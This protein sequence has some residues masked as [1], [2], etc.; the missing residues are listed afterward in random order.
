M[1]LSFISLQTSR[2]M[3]AKTKAVRS[4]QRSRYYSGFKELISSSNRAKSDFFRLIRDEVHKSFQFVLNDGG[5]ALCDS[6]LNLPDLKAYNFEEIEQNLATECPALLAALQGCVMKSKKKTDKQR[7]AMVGTIASMLGHFRRPRKCCQLQTLNGIQ[8]WM[9]GCKRKVFT[10]FNHLSWCVGVTGARKAV[11]RI[12]NNHD[13][14]LQGWKNALTRFDRGEFWTEKEPLGYSLCFDN[15]NHFITARHQSKQRQNRQLNLT[16]MYASRD[17]IPTTDL[18]NDK[19]DSDTI[20]GIPVSHLL[21]SSQEECMLRDEMV[22]ITSRIL[23]QEITPL[24]HLKNEWDI[25]H[26]YSEESSKQSDMVPLGVIEKDESK[27]DEMI[28][29]LD[30]LHKYVPRNERDG[31]GTLILH[32]DGLS[33]ERVK[34]AQ[35]ARING[36]T[37]WAQLTGLQPC[38]QEWH[39]QVIILQDIY[40]HLYNSTSGKDKMTLFHLRNVFGHHNVT[41]TVKKSYNFNAEFLEF[42]THGFIAAYALHLVGSQHSHQPLDIPSSKEDQVQ[43]V[44]SI[45]RQIVDDVFLPSQAANILHSPYCVCKDYVD[46]TTMICCDNTHCQEGSWFHLQC[47]GIPED[48][49]PKGKWYCSTECRRASSHKKKKS[50]KR[51]TKTNEQAKIDRV[52]EYNKSVIFHGLNFLIRRDAI[53]QNDGNRMIAHWKS[54]LVTFLTG[55]HNKYMVLAHRLLMGVNG[56][57]SDRIAKT[58]VWNRTV[59]P[60]GCPGRNI[61]MDLQMEMLNKTYKENVRVSRGKLTSA[62]INRHSKIIGI[63]QSLSNL[64]D[65]LTSTR[66][67]QSATSSPDRTTDTQAL[68]KMVLDYNSFDNIP[69]RAHDSFPQFQHQRPPLE[70]PAKL[71]AKLNKLTES[72][73][74]RSHLVESLNQ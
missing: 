37:Q 12:T 28:E 13:E 32:G 8:M 4:I 49:V 44:T 62:T 31:P 53:R 58:L 23:C 7:T 67:P 35:N 71:K 24:R 47:V 70:E 26:Q 38:V 1:C 40:N 27:T 64:Y 25:V 34:D 43:Y 55:T 42:A 51:E 9:A 36:A 73:A 68:I 46:E 57:F 6:S 61:A 11:D 63:G 19:P 17:R 50:C 30:T 54:D 72:M 60:S 14:K 33:C 48:R 5:S 41:A 22:I 10:R 74:D 20:R 65:E 16:Q 39:K 69:G 66:S 3:S 2:R 29:I 52:R 15:V 59:N 45:S 18:S 56:A 21:P